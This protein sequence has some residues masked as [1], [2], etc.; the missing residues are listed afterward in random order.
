MAIM[1]IFSK[2]KK[3][4][5]NDIDVYQYE[6]LPEKLRVQI[7]Q[8]VTESVGIYP[9]FYKDIKKILSK[10]LGRFQL[11]DGYPE[12]EQHECVLFIMEEQDT[13]NVLDIVELIFRY[14]EIINDGYE[15]SYLKNRYNIEQDYKESVI[16]LN[17]RF[18][19]NGVGYEYI[20]GNI[21]KIENQYIHKEIVKPA[22]QLMQEEEFKGAYQEF[23]VAHEH[24]RKREHKEAIA[25]ALKSFESTMKTIC[26]RKK[27]KYDKTK[28]TAQKLITIIFNEGLIPQYLANQFSGLRTTLETGVPTIRNKTSGHGQGEVPIEIPEYFASYA[29]NLT[30]TNIVFLVNA[31]KQSRE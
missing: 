25:N 17:H 7:V 15:I 22:L 9:G 3:A 27:Y 13:D 16:E 5:S 11:V 29:I 2:R 24:F 18:K 1:D 28:D 8:L 19:E 20:N 4:E 14:I 30:A 12:N 21:I 23:I 31:Y 10:E 26:E 6:L